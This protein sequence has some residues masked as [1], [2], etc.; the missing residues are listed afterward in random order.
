MARSS[1]FREQLTEEGREAG[2]S[3]MKRE[4]STRP[5]TDTCGTPRPRNTFEISN[6]CDFE[7]PRKHAYQK[8]KIKPNEQ[9][10]VGGQPK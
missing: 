6:C 5:R 10:K 3:L 7:K 2:R 8:G 9:S 4:K 1:A